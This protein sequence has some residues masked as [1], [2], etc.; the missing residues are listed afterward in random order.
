[1]CRIVGIKGVC[2]PFSFRVFS[3]LDVHH[4]ELTEIFEIIRKGLFR[5]REFLP[6]IQDLDQG[7]ELK[8][9]VL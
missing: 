7:G 2:R 9:V 3:L 1:M 8:L 5:V 6:W 4:Q